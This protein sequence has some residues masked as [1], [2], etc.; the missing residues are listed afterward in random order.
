MGTRSYDM[1]FQLLELTKKC[2]PINIE[3]KDELICATI[4][5]NSSEETTTQLIQSL[6]CLPLLATRS[7]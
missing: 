6:L 7:G 1:S 3:K 2:I 4:Q 5:T